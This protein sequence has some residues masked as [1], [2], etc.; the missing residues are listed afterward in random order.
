MADTT[1]T[2]YGL[3]KPEDG[4]STGTWGPKVNTDMDLIDT[5]M[6]VNE[7]DAA[8]A[9]TAADAALPLVGGVLSGEVD[10]FTARMERSD[11]GNWSGAET[12]DLDNANAF[13]ATVTGST[14]ITISN[15]PAGTHLIAFTVRITNGG[16]FPITWPGTVEWPGGTVP[17]FT[18][19]GTDVVTMLSFDAGTTWQAN[20]VLDLS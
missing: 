4:A 8:T 13:T 3:T 10:I 17:T 5:Q 14:T 9:Q 1:T 15:A 2:N 7:D 16:V 12:I 20:V 11:L 18:T 19:S 6:K